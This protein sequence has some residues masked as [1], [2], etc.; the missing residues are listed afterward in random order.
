MNTYKCTRDFME[1][2]TGRYFKAGDAVDESTFDATRLAAYLDRG[3]VE[4][5]TEPKPTRARS[6]KTKDG[7]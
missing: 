1:V 2:K 7:E 5:I 6:A 3:W 4:P